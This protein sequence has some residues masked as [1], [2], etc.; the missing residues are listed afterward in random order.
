[1]KIAIITGGETGERSVSL[2]SAE[3]IRKAIDFAETE[4]FI[5]PEDR[6]GF[7]EKVSTFDLAIPVIHGIGGEDGSLQAL[8]KILEIPFIFSDIGAHARAINKRNT[9]EL[10]REIG[11]AVPKE[12]E[13]LPFF[14]KPNTG[15]SSIASKLC[16]SYEEFAELQKNNQEI[17]FLTEELVKGREFT[18]GVLEHGRK[19]F[20]L[21]VIEIVPKGEF[22]DFENK[23]NPEKLASEICPANIDAPLST[24]LQ[25]Q[26]L[27]IHK[28]LGCRHISRSDF[29]MTPDNQIYFLEINTIPGMTGTSLVPKMLKHVNLSLREVLYG[30]CEENFT[31]AQ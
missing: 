30:W 27:T 11:I 9:K 15:G 22:F 19:T 24:E 28:H 31:K 21:P 10:V 13:T 25:Q 6:G 17:D 23:Y 7:V 2:K 12:T 1:M 3:N 26:A 8:F 14:A 29:I 16:Q 5:F 4:T 18:V 20:A